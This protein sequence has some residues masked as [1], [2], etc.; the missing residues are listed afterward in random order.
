MRDWRMPDLLPKLYLFSVWFWELPRLL[1]IERGL[2]Q[3]QWDLGSV[4]ECDWSNML[5]MF[6]VWMHS[7]RGLTQMRSLQHQLIVLFVDW[8]LVPLLRSLNKSFHWWYHFG[9]R[10]LLLI[11]VRQL[12]E[13]HSLQLMQCN[14]WLLSQW[15]WSSLL[16]M[17]SIKLHL[18]WIFNEV[19][20]MR[21]S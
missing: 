9:L 3:V 13:S 18:L 11:L 5:S 1:S 17:Y 2:L 12:H 20:N 4:P 15:V 19:Q 21:R 10:G 8:F 6:S 14:G 16:F 7:M